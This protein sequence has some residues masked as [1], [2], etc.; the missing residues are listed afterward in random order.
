MKSTSST[1]C[2][3]E[4]SQNQ[5]TVDSR[6]AYNTD[7]SLSTHL[8]VLINSTIMKFLHKVHSWRSA[9]LLRISTYEID[10]QPDDALGWLLQP[11]VL[12]FLPHYWE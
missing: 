2:Q 6:N 11:S 3:H 12:V 7:K 1:V 10:S 4:K 9:L 8:V 5:R